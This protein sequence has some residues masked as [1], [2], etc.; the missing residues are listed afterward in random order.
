MTEVQQ[1]C[2][3]YEQGV[4]KGRKNRKVTAI[5]NCENPY[6]NDSDEF[7]AWDYGYSEGKEH[8]IKLAKINGRKVS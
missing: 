7:E 5:G 6:S 1:I 2:F 3:A 4:G 8:F